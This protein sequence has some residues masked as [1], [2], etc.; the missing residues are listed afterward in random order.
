MISTASAPKHPY[1]A[2][3]FRPAELDPEDIAAMT[4]DELAKRKATEV[5][6]ESV[7]RLAAS[8]PDLLKALQFYANPENWK[9]ADTGI[10]PMPSEVDSDF[11]S[12]AQE[13]IRKAIG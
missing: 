10:G 12:I 3:C 4:P 11:G 7:V 9:E 6:A 1:I 2:D 13:A 8:A 5:E